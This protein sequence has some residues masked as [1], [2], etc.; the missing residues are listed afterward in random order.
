M[1][2]RGKVG[3]E[4]IREGLSYYYLNLAVNF[5]IIINGVFRFYIFFEVL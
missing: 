1:N 5:G 4:F 2:Y 3:G